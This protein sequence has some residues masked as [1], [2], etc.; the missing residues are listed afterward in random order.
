MY[1]FYVCKGTKYEAPQGP[2]FKRVNAIHQPI[3]IGSNG[4]S[5]KDVFKKFSNLITAEVVQQTQC[6]YLFDI[7]GSLWLL[8]LRNGAGCVKQVDSDT[9]SDVRMV[10][11]E[12]VLVD[13]FTGKQKASTAYMTGKLK[14]KGDIGNAMKLE[15][16]IM[17]TKS[18]L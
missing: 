8:D 16:L 13:L 2:Y 9:D 10:I 6:T 1:F 14:L 18:K 7:E 4:I 15:R 3:A 11:K 5:L 12:D 17:L